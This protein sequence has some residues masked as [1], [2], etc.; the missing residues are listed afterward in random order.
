MLSDERIPIMYSNRFLKM[1]TLYCCVSADVRWAAS[2]RLYESDITQGEMEKSEWKDQSM[3]GIA[4]KLLKELTSGGKGS[5]TVFPYK[6]VTCS[7]E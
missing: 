3:Y 4:S 2:E 5:A 7:S 6:N 1:E